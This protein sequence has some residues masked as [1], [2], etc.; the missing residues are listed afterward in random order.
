MMK[1]LLLLAVLPVTLSAALPDVL[2]LAPARTT[3]EVRAYGMGFLPL[4]GNFTTFDGMLNYD[5]ADH[6][7]CRVDLRVDVASLTM[8]NA[9]IRATLLG[10][11]YMDAAQF[12]TLRFE[13]A[14]QADDLVGNLTM[15]GVTRSFTMETTRGARELTAQGSLRRGDWGMTNTSMI[16]G[17]TVRITVRVH[18][19]PV[20]EAG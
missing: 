13:G 19:P 15:H 1:H 10:P 6:G 17:S 18:L 5:A 9:A 14:C 11:D 7:A 8:S 12:P 16:A 20:G 4:D 2:A 3:V